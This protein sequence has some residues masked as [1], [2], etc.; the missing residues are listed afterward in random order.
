MH[1]TRHTLPFE[2]RSSI[3]RFS[4]PRIANR[5]PS[6]AFQSQQLQRFGLGVGRCYSLIP[7]VATIT[8]GIRGAL[9]TATDTMGEER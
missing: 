4:S 2:I 1:G 3:P 7:Q 5:C 8:A 6:M 9:L